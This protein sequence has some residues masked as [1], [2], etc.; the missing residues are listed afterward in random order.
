MRLRD[1]IELKVILS[2]VST[3]ATSVFRNWISNQATKWRCRFPSTPEEDS[4]EEQ[5]QFLVTEFAHLCLSRTNSFKTRNAPGST[6]T[7]MPETSQPYP[8]HTTGRISDI[9]E[10]TPRETADREVLPKAS[11]REEIKSPEV[12]MS[13]PIMPTMSPAI[14]PTRSDATRP[15]PPSLLLAPP[16]SRP[17]AVS[18]GANIQR[19]ANPVS[20]PSSIESSCEPRP[21]THKD[22]PSISVSEAERPRSFHSEKFLG[23]KFQFCNP[24]GQ[25]RKMGESRDVL[26]VKRH[27]RAFSAHDFDGEKFS[28]QLHYP[29]PN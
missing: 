11:N 29:T 12:V 27:V 21:S 16:E 5:M 17:R 28:F 24:R 6:E 14:S 10:A 2:N 3:W 4:E 9:T 23:A 8:P 1:V 15:D 7:M 26:A 20:F 25:Y 22:A 18:V 13:Q 19:G